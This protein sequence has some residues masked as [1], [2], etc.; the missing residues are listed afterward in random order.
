MIIE[1]LFYSYKTYLVEYANKIY[2]YCNSIGFE[3]MYYCLPKK[4]IKYARMPK[5]KILTTSILK[6]PNCEVKNLYGN[7]FLYTAPGCV[8]S[9]ENAKI[10][11]FS[12]GFGNDDFF[13]SKCK[14]GNEQRTVEYLGG[15]DY[16]T[17]K[18]FTRKNNH[19][20]K[21]RT[22]GL[23]KYDQT[24]PYNIE[25]EIMKINFQQNTLEDIYFD[26]NKPTILFLHT[27]DK[28]NETETSHKTRGIQGISN[29]EETAKQLNKISND[30]NIIHKNH[31]NTSN[32]FSNF[33][34]IDNGTVDSKFLFDIADIIIADYGGSAL[35]SLLSDKKIIYVNDYNHEK[36]SHLNIDARIHN[37]FDN[38][39]PED[40]LKHIDIPMTKEQ[41]EL[42]LELRNYFYGESL[43]KPCEKFIKCIKDPN[44]KLFDEQEFLNNEITKK[45]NLGWKTKDI[46]KVLK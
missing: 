20:E 22:I 27:W 7:Y 39:Y 6:K 12:Y 33:I 18:F 38:C 10:H 30:F 34:N 32:L 5:E 40:I 46:K 13:Y 21:F 4:S 14:W 25:N 3:D 16:E 15:C 37:S 44:Y 31:H 17:H 45:Y 19:I 41:E 26:K 23:I 2:D 24:I 28:A 36:I 9:F 29:Y 35:E 8:K 42:R 43:D 1:H 11:K